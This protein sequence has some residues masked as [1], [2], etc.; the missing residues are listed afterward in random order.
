MSRSPAPGTRPRSYSGVLLAV[1]FFLIA[2][3]IFQVGN[4]NRTREHMGLLERENAL[5]RELR[6]QA[7]DLTKE[8]DYLKQQVAAVRKEVDRWKSRFRE[9]DE[10]NRKLQVDLTRSATEVREARAALQ[11]GRKKPK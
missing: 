9:K 3:L 5:V 6:Q 7:D 1:I 8:R 2:L 4:Q 11:K 10:Q